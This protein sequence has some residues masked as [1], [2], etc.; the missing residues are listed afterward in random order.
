MKDWTPGV[1]APP[2]APCASPRI[3]RFKE[4][5]HIARKKYYIAL[6]PLAQ[7]TQAFAE[8]HSASV[9]VIASYCNLEGDMD[10]FRLELV[11]VLPD[12]VE[13][14]EL[15][16][17]LGIPQPAAV[18]RRSITIDRDGRA[19]HHTKSGIRVPVFAPRTASQTRYCD[20]PAAVAGVP[21]TAPP[22]RFATPVPCINAKTLAGMANRHTFCTWH[23]D[24]PRDWMAPN[25]GA[26]TQDPLDILLIK[27]VGLHPSGNTARVELRRV[28]A[29]GATSSLIRRHI[30]DAGLSTNTDYRGRPIFAPLSQQHVAL[31]CAMLCDKIDAGAGLMRKMHIELATGISMP[32]A[33]RTSYV[34]PIEDFYTRNAVSPDCDYQPFF[35][36]QHK[37][38]FAVDARKLVRKARLLLHSRHKNRTDGRS[39]ADAILNRDRTLLRD[40]PTNIE[41]EQTTVKEDKTMAN[42]DK[43]SLFSSIFS[44]LRSTIPTRLAEGGKTGLACGTAGQIAV[45]ALRKSPLGPIYK[46]MRKGTGG[47]RVKAITLYLEPIVGSIAL[48]ALARAFKHYGYEL[49]LADFGVAAFQRVIEGETV[50]AAKPLAAM[51]LPMVR[52]AFAEVAELQP[53]LNSEIE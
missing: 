31:L 51:L 38:L 4:L 9:W 21:K 15:R 24:S 43:P 53:K 27:S 45:K 47:K 1:K 30:D 34:I 25:T 20:V 40:I 8:E 19:R 44:D 17:P 28:N 35:S 2:M 23:P 16:G 6:H 49:P 41:S 29:L 32:G 13:I 7:Y 12:P 46:P 14:N 10:K 42:N 37:N 36:S 48:I 11:R 52:K 39:R 5:Q 33:Y 3:L 50:I 26:A 18:I 22:K